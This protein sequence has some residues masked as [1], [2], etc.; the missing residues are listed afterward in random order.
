MSKNYK[1][2]C[3]EQRYQIEALLNAGHTQKSISISLGVHASTIHRELKRNTA[4]A[5]RGAG[6]YRADNAQWKTQ[7]RHRKK[8]KRILFDE[9]QKVICRRG[10]EN[11][12]YSPELISMEG[13]QAE[14]SF[15]SHET[16]YKWIWKCKK[17]NRAADRKDKKLYLKLRHGHRRRK[18]GNIHDNRGRIPGRVSIEKRPLIVAK[19]ERLGDLEVDLMIGRNH[20]SA[21]LISMDRASLKVKLKKLKSKQSEHVECEL[22]NSYCNDS[23]WV[24]TIT[25]DNDSAFMN[26]QKIG[27]ALQ[28]K[29]YFTR[30]YTSQD[31]G[32]IENR[33]G[34]LRRF[35]PK[36]SDLSHI[37]SR[38]L[39]DVENKLNNRP[40]RKFKYKTPNQVFSEKIAL[41]S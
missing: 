33:I 15:V 24:K 2:L 20:Q 22:I 31:K 35:F 37:T 39:A 41:M 23:H 29:T 12:K 21:I 7:E 9:H 27:K 17:G 32:G 1:H 19:K 25:F 38:Q 4:K 16:I 10:L 8:P 3:Q 13:K 14:D 36:G 26:H 11:K 34:V 28:A 30:P 5:G 18:R 40:V 6:Q